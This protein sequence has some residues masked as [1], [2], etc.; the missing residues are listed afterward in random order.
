MYVDTNTDNGREEKKHRPKL[1]VKPYHAADAKSY[2]YLDR[3]YGFFILPLGQPINPIYGCF[4]SFLLCF[5]RLG[6][7]ACLPGSRYRAFI[8]ILLWSVFDLV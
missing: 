1:R 5:S 2:K 3:Q 4:V 8:A 6:G 7:L